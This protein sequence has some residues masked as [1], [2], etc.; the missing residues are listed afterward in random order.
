ML[1]IHQMSIWMRIL[2][3][4]W[5]E[6]SAS[7]FYFSLRQSSV[8][9]TNNLR[10]SII[11][12]F[13]WIK[14]ANDAYAISCVKSIRILSAKNGLLSSTRA[15]DSTNCLYADADGSVQ[16][17]FSCIIQNCAVKVTLSYSYQ[18]F[19]EWSIYSCR[20][21]LKSNSKIFSEPVN[22]D[23]ESSKTEELSTISASIWATLGDGS[24]PVVRKSIAVL[25]SLLGTFL[26]VSQQSQPVS[27]IALLHQMEKE[28]ITVNVR[29]E[30]STMLQR[31]DKAAYTV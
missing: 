16:S 27:G 5:N 2:C 15:H 23:G 9:L 20:N 3:H 31:S 24:E 30:L 19:I 1:R 18:H 13:D 12:I 7:L 6:H 28:S 26:F 11:G 21:I 14:T 22:T 4:R 8:T 25:S 29:M 10:T 17:T